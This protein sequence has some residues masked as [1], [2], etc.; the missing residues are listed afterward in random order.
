M[1]KETKERLKKRLKELT[2]RFGVSGAEQEVVSYLKEAFS[3]HAD[4]VEIDSW[5]NLYAKKAGTGEGP[6]LMV[7]AHSDEIGMVV[8]SIHEDGF[9]SFDRVGGVNDI[10]LPGRKVLIGGRIPGVIGVKAGHLQKEEEKTRVRSIRDSYID[11][12]AF[13][14]D[15]A[16]AMGIRVGDRITFQS[17]FMEMYNPDLVSTKSVD[18]RVS[19]AILL[20][21]FEQLSKE[22]FAGTLFGVVCVQEEI[23]LRGATMAGNRIKPDWAIVL[24]TI[25]CGDTPDINTESELPVKLGKGPVCPLIDGI[26]GAFMGN[27]VH[28][29]IREFI[30]KHSEKTGVNVQYVTL[31]SE[32][33]TT[34]ATHVSMSG[35]GVPTG[36][37]TTPRRYSHSPVELVNLNDAVG[38]LKLLK[39]LVE[40]NGSEEISFL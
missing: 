40:S 25:P 10:L 24:D 3:P 37:L 4:S 18:N 12:G 31:S 1:T 8:K 17:D 21:L 7:S 2:S 27:V 35:T 5:G 14:R 22:D 26:S 15:E 33:Y 38:L 29:K 11:V 20:E 28:P 32:F 34:D 36:L 16:E 9:I 39:S 19:C 30:E 6:V 13:T 23:G